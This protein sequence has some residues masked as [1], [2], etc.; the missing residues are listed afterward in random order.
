MYIILRRLYVTMLDRT[1]TQI[2]R[3]Y[4]KKQFSVAKVKSLLTNVHTK[5]DSSQF[6]KNSAE[7]YNISIGF[8]FS[9]VVVDSF[10]LL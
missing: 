7:S 3:I 6:T 8:R 5:I 10:Q 1:D 2:K 9:V 4:K